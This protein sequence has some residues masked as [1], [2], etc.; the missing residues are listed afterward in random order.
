MSV[1]LICGLN[2][3]GKTT[4]GIKL[5]NELGFQFL[6]DED[7]Y[8]LKSDILFS[9]SRTDEE[10]REF[11]TSYI[12]Q[13]KN[14]VLTA[15]RGDLGDKI[16]SFYDYVIYLFAPLE[17]RL[18]RIKK[19]EYDRFGE[20]VLK[21]GDMYE[22]Q[23]I[24]HNFVVSRTTEKIEKWLNTLSCRVIKLDGSKPI[25]DN[26]ELIKNSYDSVSFLS[27]NCIMNSTKLN[28]AKFA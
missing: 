19:R 6:N 11:I 14:V 5:A 26:V 23:K 1:I 27:P 15:T 20:R 7:Y 16:N 12:E 2:G 28:S 18:S 21:G 10:V 22:Q 3:S 9:K 25:D 4:L 13:H 17:L 24:F 8:F